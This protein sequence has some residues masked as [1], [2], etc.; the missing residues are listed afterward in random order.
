MGRNSKRPAQG[1]ASGG[2]NA[3]KLGGEPRCYGSYLWIMIPHLCK[4]TQVRAA[5]PTKYVFG[6][7]AHGL[8]FPTYCCK[9]NASAVMPDYWDV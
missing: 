7:K 6:L 4:R 5:R 8:L 2:S 1:R 9:I 3:G